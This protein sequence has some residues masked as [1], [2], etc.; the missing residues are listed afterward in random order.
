M[1]DTYYLICALCARTRIKRFKRLRDL[2]I[3]ITVV[4]HK[5]VRIRIDQHGAIRIVGTKRLR[6][7]RP[8]VL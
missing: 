2:H 4:H 8:A 5:R 3:H 6:L 7:R 1:P